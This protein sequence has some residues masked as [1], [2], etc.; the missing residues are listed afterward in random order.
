LNLVREHISRF[1]RGIDPKDAM[2]TGL[3]YRIEKWLEDHYHNI[4]NATKAGYYEINSD[5]TIDI[6]GFFATDWDKNFPDYIQFNECY[7]SFQ[8]S[9]IDEG[10]MTSLRGCPRIV[11]GDFECCR[12]QLKNLVGGP[13]E[14]HGKYVCSCIET[15]K[16]LEGLAKY[17]GEYLA[18]NNKS[19][20]TIN[21]IPKGTHIE[22]IDKSCVYYWGGY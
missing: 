1:E 18:C 22:Q 20:L 12:Q 15:L 17:I 21:N 16:S 6:H 2:Q 11:R 13:E 8:I 19:G 3:K 5:S 7:G 10:Y 4:S 9:A 14:V